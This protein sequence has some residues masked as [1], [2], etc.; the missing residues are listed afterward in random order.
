MEYLLNDL[1]N[2]SLNVSGPADTTDVAEEV[3]TEL[4][5]ARDEEKMA[6]Q[7]IYDTAFEERIPNK[8]WVLNLDLPDLAEIIK[9]TFNLGA[10]SKN[11]EESKELCKFYLKGKCTFKGRCRFSHSLPLEAGGG[12]ADLSHPIYNTLREVEADRKPPFTLEIRFPQ[13]C[14]YPLEAP[15]VAFS[16]LDENLTAHTRLNISQFLMT[17]ARDSA[18]DG[19]PCV[20]NLVSSLEDKAKLEELIALPPPALSKPVMMKPPPAAEPEPYQTSL[21]QPEVKDTSVKET[22]S[23]KDKLS[24]PKDREGAEGF[25]PTQRRKED[26]PKTSN[27]NEIKKQ[28]KILLDEFKKKQVSFY[29]FKCSRFG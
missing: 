29:Y 23:V 27:R 12:M 14:K 11:R 7:S 15:L 10:E 26:V 22:F 1:F 20:F 9:T 25:V 5:E 18:Q 19:L 3:D 2:I 6:L 16:A 21:K 13:G 4:L 24:A 8:C 28:N 17:L